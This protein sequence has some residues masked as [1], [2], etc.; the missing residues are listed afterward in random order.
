M[1]T[2][3]SL[4]KRLARLE[5]QRPQH[6]A[7]QLAVLQAQLDDAI[8]KINSAPN[9]IAALAA[10]DKCAAILARMDAIQRLTPRWAEPPPQLTL[11]EAMAV[12]NRWIAST[13][14]SLGA[15]S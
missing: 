3:D 9:N 10:Y 8:P 7:D 12:Y 11:A 6:F 2:L 1:P 4:K 14:S 13:A 15:T 5:G